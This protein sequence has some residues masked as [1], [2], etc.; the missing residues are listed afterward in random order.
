MALGGDKDP[1]AVHTIIADMANDPTV[2]ELLYDLLEQQPT[3]V[4]VWERII[5][6]WD[7]KNE[8]GTLFV[9]LRKL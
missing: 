8:R 5:E 6:A 3:N 7:A 1:K 4:Y 9:E 2:I